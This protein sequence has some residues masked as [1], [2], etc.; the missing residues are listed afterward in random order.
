M[1]I[2]DDV[3]KALEASPHVAW[4]RFVE[5]IL[6]RLGVAVI[7]GNLPETLRRY[8]WLSSDEGMDPEIA[9][10]LYEFTAAP[11]RRGAAYLAHRANA[12]GVTKEEILVLAATARADTSTILPQEAGEIA[13]AM[14]APRVAPRHD[15]TAKST[16]PAESPREGES[17]DDAAIRFSLMELN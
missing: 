5:L 15:D 6:T 11:W 14:V 12:L 16:I 3:M 2:V 7:P 1:S 13:A 4:S 10:C 8:A 9:A 17:A